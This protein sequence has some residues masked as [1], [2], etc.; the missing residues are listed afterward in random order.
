[1]R[2]IKV[3]FLLP[4][5]KAGGAERVM[6]YVFSTINPLKFDAELL[7]IGS[8]KDNHYD[9]NSEKKVSYLN[10][11]KLR[12]AIW[13]IPYKIN[14]VQPDIV[15]SSI[16]HI[17]FYLGFIK[18]FFPKVFFI[19]REANVKSIRSHFS[20]AFILPKRLE[21]FFLNKADCI[22][23][24]S[25]DMFD[26]LSINYKLSKEKIKLIYNPL[27][28]KIP[29][30]KEKKE[31]KKINFL[32]LASLQKKKGIL[33]LISILSKV[34]FDYEY[35]ILGKGPLEYSIKKKIEDLNLTKKI[36]IFPP[37][38]N[39][40][41]DIKKADFFLLGSYVEGFPNVILEAFSAGLP[42][43]AFN[44]YGG[45][46]EQIIDGFN[47]YLCDDEYDFQCKLELAINKSWNP[48]AIKKDVLYRYNPKK[49]IYQYE[50]VFS[51]NKE[52]I[53]M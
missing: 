18:V 16:G 47:G 49:I 26:D 1:M 40:D 2:K 39:F 41:D 8:E 12:E 20:E 7:V 33:R 27:T 50:E 43:I 23:V 9:L 32:T 30:K 34:K 45:H 51:K 29:L 24:Q 35:I 17:N 11:K 36:K 22:I 5:L 13:L 19:I 15:I 44:S 42:C 14:K 6:S 38:K 10:K 25:K 46:R 52:I 31:S 21:M 28:R 48:S 37:K 3:L 4:H 53:G